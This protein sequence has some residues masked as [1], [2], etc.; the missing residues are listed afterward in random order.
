M[1]DNDLNSIKALVVSNK[2]GGIKKRLWYIELFTISLLLCFVFS[3]ISQLLL[4]KANIALALFLVLLLIFVSV[5]FDIIGVAVAASNI[6]PFL[7]LKQNGGGRGVEMAISLVKKADKV[8][9]ICADVVG[10]ICSI[11]SGASGVAIS[12]ILISELPSISGAV[13]STFVSS[14][15]AALTVLGKALG[16]NIALTNSTKILLFV[17]K[18]LSI[19]SRKHKKSKI[20]QVKKP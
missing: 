12:I 3:I 16:K 13:L 1:D 8:S 18:M 11:V 4:I 17:G 10:D 15:I 5:V 7:E 20:K 2:Q 14:I 19:F 6:K 9:S